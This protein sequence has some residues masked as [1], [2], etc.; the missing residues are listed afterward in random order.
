VDFDDEITGYLMSPIDT[1]HF[2][3]NGFQIF[4]NV[5]P[6]ELVEESRSA[7]EES[8]LRS[9]RAAREE[10]D[11]T[12]EVDIVQIIDDVAKGVRSKIE[13]L[14]K[15]TRDTLT[16]HISLETRLSKEIRTLP[17]HK[18]VQA[19]VK[20]L[21]NSEQVFMHMPPTPRFVLAGNLHA[22]VPPHPDIA[23]NKH[24]TNFIVIW[25]PLVDID[26][27]CGGVVVFQGSGH[28]PE[29]MVMGHPEHFWQDA[30]AT[31]GFPPVHCV[32]QRGDILAL[33]KWIIHGSKA[34]HSTKTRY[35]IDCRFFGE[36][37]IS[38][39]HFL[40]LQKNLVIAPNEGNDESF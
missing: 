34:N 2:L 26:E 33:N 31:N 38:T 8:S 7:L 22:G 25:I 13:T 32:L 30:V 18:N 20:A 16:G 14:S 5:L 39:K 17:T 12:A 1:T 40:D 29:Q 11:C 10:L 23:Y 37:D 27:D 19:I 15:A 9:L 36:G 24:L 35:S 21:L 4:R 6:L 3:Q 28:V